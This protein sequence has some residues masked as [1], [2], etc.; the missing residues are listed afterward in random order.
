M[1][2]S[3]ASQVFEK[4]MAAKPAGRYFLRLFVAGATPRSRQAVRR[5]FQLCEGAQKDNYDLEVIDVYQQPELA[6][7]CQIVAT[8]TLIKMR[9]EPMRRFIGHLLNTEGLFDE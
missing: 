8:P 7:T 3:R 4:A 2:P 1:K 9:P 5:V 6:R